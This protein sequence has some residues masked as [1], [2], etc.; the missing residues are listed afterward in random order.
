MLTFTLYVKA[1]K[2]MLLTLQYV[3]N[4]AAAVLDSFLHMLEKRLY[5]LL[6]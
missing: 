4:V 2:E 5:A 3:F 6:Y 1:R